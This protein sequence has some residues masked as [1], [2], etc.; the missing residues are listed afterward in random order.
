[1]RVEIEKSMHALF[2]TMCKYFILP[3]TKPCT[4]QYVITITDAWG[5]DPLPL[6]FP[7]LPKYRPPGRYSLLSFYEILLIYLCTLIA[8]NYIKQPFKKNLT[9]SLYKMFVLGNFVIT[10]YRKKYPSTSWAVFM[11]YDFILLPKFAFMIIP[12]AS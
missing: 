2:C 6:P 11:Y 3:C 7:P 12:H 8:Q 10:I 4:P 5:Q 1:M 9:L